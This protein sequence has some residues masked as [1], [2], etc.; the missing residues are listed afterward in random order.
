VTTSYGDQKRTDF[1][2][3][4]ATPSLSV[5][6]RLADCGIVGALQAQSFVRPGQ[7]LCIYP[8]VNNNGRAAVTSGTADLTIQS[9]YITVLNGTHRTFGQIPSKSS[10][11][12]PSIQIFVATNVPA[13]HQAVATWQIAD[14]TGGAY[15]NQE[16]WLINSYPG[17]VVPPRVQN[18]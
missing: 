3:T 2:L 6:S 7:S 15:T 9:A 16:T 18:S 11:Y 8:T 1:S 14:N 17:D 12:P 10:A 5:Q 4:A 13:G